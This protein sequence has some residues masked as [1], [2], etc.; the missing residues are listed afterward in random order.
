MMSSRDLSLL[1]RALRYERD[2]GEV[3]WSCVCELAS[4][5]KQQQQQKPKPKPNFL[6]PSTDTQSLG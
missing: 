1:R 3:S 5:P 6:I 2:T 4:N